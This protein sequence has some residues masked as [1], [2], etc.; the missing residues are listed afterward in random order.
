MKKIKINSNIITAIQD[1]YATARLTVFINKYIS[2]NFDIQK[3]VRQSDSLLCILYNITI[4]SLALKIMQDNKILDFINT[5]NKSHKVNM[6]V[7]DIAVYLTSLK[8][9]KYFKKCYKFFH[10]VCEMNLNEAKCEIITTKIERVLTR[11]EIITIIHWISSKY[12]NI[13]INN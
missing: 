1:C 11:L 9:W 5:T 3:D 8:Q 2:V 13:L 4:K 6:Y 7:D 10:D 12:W